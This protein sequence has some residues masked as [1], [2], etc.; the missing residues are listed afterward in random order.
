MFTSVVSPYLFALITD[1]L[2]AHIQEEVPWGILFAND[3]VLVEESRDGVNIK[4][5]RWREA[6]KSKGFKINHTK[7][8]TYGLKL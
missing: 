6:F 7:T 3:I 4:L 8:K 1:A 5:K 2:T